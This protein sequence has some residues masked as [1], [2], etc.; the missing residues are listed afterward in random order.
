MSHK[1][2]S[3]G[4]IFLFLHF[5]ANVFMKSLRHGGHVFV[6]WCITPTPSPVRPHPGLR[7]YFQASTR[8]SPCS[9]KSLFSASWRHHT[10]VFFNYNSCVDTAQYLTPYFNTSLYTLEAQFN[11][12]KLR[13]RKYYFQSK[14]FYFF[15][16]NEWKV[17]LSNYFLFILQRRY[18]T[19]ER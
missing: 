12:F 8:Y 15:S 10:S 17:L 7:R 1:I 18:T 4:V 13:Y 5:I 16:K 6:L 19:D 3:R 9:E 14:I 2:Y 11:P